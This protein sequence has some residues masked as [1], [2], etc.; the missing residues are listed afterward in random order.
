MLCSAASGATRT[1]TSFSARRPAE[2]GPPGEATFYIRYAGNLDAI[3]SALRRAT[4]E[5]DAKVPIVAVRTMEAQLDSAKWPV[6]AIITLAVDLRRRLAADCRHRSVRGGR[7]RRA[8]PDARLRRPH[9][10]GRLVVA[11]S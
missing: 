10:P 6:R 11:T 7:V 5:V 2:P 1:R 3:T 8:A 9:G 4:L